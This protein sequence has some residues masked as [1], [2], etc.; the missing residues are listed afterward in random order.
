MNVT[1][2]VTDEL[3]E[4]L[5]GPL[6]PGGFRAAEGTLVSGE[7]AFRVQVSDNW[8]GRLTIGHDP[9]NADLSRSAETSCQVLSNRVDG[10]LE[11]AHYDNTLV[12]G[13]LAGTFSAW[14]STLTGPFTC[15]NLEI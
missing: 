1:D 11:I 7:E 2:Y 5:N 3:T 10:A 6:D 13:N 15:S 9:G 12:S 4:A 14:I 8:C